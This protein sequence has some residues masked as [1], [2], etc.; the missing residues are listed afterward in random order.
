MI[1]DN[2]FFDQ[3]FE[4][5]QFHTFFLLPW[6]LATYFVKLLTKRNYI[7]STIS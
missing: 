3:G 5:Y 2:G 7:L 6:L 4:A 1:K